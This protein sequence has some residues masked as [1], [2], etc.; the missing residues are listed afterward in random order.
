MGGPGVQPGQVEN[1]IASGGLTDRAI[2]D[3]ETALG[4]YKDPFWN[5]DQADQV[6]KVYAA[7][8]QLSGNKTKIGKEQLKSFVKKAEQER[9]KK[10]AEEKRKASEPPA[11][12]KDPKAANTGSD[13]G[14]GKKG[15][16]ASEGNGAEDG[17]G[18]ALTRFAIGDEVHG[19]CKLAALKAEFDGKKGKVLKANARDYVVELLE[20][21]AKG[22]THKYPHNMVTPVLKPASR[23]KAL[24]DLFKG[25][26][27]AVE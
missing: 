23:Q 13:T 1:L 12:E 11:G 18:A 16:S 19:K 20:G 24:D 9:L 2:S 3:A 25:K 7:L 6:T 5:A 15:A 22:T 8:K 26:D 14:G 27:T 17:K 10:R 21:P 4:R